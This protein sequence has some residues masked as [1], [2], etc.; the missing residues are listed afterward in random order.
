MSKLPTRTD[1][2]SPGD[3]LLTYR[4]TDGGYRGVGVDTLAA[5]LTGVV[6]G[7]DGKTILSGVGDPDPSLGVIGD[8]YLSI[9]NWMLFGP[10]DATW[11]SGVSLVGPDGADGADAPIPVYTWVGDKLAVN[12]VA[13]GP[14][15]TGPTGPQGVKGD[16][17][18]TG[19]QGLI[20][21]TGATGLTGPQGA[22]GIQGIQGNTGPAGDRGPTGLTGPEGPAG[23]AGAD[24]VVPG[25]QGP[26]GPTGPEGP[27]GAAGEVP[28]APTDGQQYA[29]KNAGWVVV[30]GGS[31]TPEVYVQ[32][33][34]PGLTNPGIWI[35]TGLG[36]GGLGFTFWFEDGL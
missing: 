15:L 34:D 3:L 17:G 23:P 6:S 32:D 19:P 16:T 1:S 31:G 27:A 21:L 35:Q 30:T 13:S 18:D 12:G 36:P 2:V 11:G 24:S 33:T 28:E 7:V 14:A 9:N 10:K 25:P 29:R 8:F 4:S 5:Y 22:Q 20:G 26:A